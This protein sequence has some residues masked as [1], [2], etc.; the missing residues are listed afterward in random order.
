MATTT[1]QKLRT[2]LQGM[3]FNAKINALELV[4]RCTSPPKPV[5]TL[6]PVSVL[7]TVVFPEPAKPTRP[8]LMEHLACCG[9]RQRVSTVLRVMSN[10]LERTDT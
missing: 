2:V 8:T 10:V 7:K 5:G 1:N 6:R 4:P 3:T 9:D